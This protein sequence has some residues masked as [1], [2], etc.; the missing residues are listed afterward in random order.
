M[1]TASSSH[2]GG[3]SHPRWQW[4]SKTDGTSHKQWSLLDN[5]EGELSQGAHPF[6]L[7]PADGAGLDVKISVTNGDGLLLYFD[8]LPISS[9]CP[10]PPLSFSP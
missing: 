8:F 2:H 3:S 9:F 1:Q 7:L 5:K 4:P 6:L 10:S